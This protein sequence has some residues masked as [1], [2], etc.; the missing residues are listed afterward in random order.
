MRL[1]EQRHVIKFGLARVVV[2][3]RV[4]ASADGRVLLRLLQ[5]FWGNKTAEIEE[6]LL[7][8]CTQ[9]LFYSP[10][11]TR[12]GAARFGACCRC[13]SVRAHGNSGTCFFTGGYEVLGHR[14][15]IKM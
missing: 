13:C 3:A 7:L 10:V 11:F 14:G 15:A 4:C 6:S 9:L 5:H 8:I 1:T 12:H 2:C